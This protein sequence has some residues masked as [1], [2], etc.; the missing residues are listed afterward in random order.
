LKREAHLDTMKIDR[1]QP[2]MEPSSSTGRRDST[3]NAPQRPRTPIERAREMR[4]HAQQVCARAREMREHA[5]RMLENSAF[6]DRRRT[7]PRP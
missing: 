7:V 6:R 5:K 1:R 4:E 2:G 3:Q